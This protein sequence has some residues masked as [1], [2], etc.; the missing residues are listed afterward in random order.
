MTA[1]FGFAGTGCRLQCQHMV[2]LGRL[3]RNT[4]GFSDLQRTRRVGA[5]CA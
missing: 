3:K 2:G 1:Q 5:A 4:T